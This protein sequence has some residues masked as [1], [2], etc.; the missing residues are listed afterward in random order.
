MGRVSRGRPVNKFQLRPGSA[1]RWARASAGCGPRHPETAGWPGRLALVEP[2]NQLEQFSH[3]DETL[4]SES[5]SGACIA[6]TSRALPE[7][8]GQR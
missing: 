7:L 6:A 8:R 2:E 3:S 5:P 4:Q 1:A